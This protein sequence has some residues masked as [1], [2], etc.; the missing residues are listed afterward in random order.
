MLIYTSIN[1]KKNAQLIKII[2]YGSSYRKYIN[3]TT[4]KTLLFFCLVGLFLGVD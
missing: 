3:I 1:F 4:F 2:H